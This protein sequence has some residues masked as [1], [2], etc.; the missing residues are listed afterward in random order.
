MII[1]EQLFQELGQLSEEDLKRVADYVSFLKSKARTGR[2]VR[3][4]EANLKALYAEA[5]EEDRMIAQEGMAE[6]SAGL[7]KEDKQ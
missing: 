7:K 4:D 3:L 6:Y 2:V 5:G 1:R